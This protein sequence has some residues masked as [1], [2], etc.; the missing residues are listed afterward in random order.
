MLI[1]ILLPIIIV[2]LVDG[3]F[4]L[5]TFVSHRLLI[6]GQTLKHQRT[7]VSEPRLLARS[8]ALFH[9][10]MNIITEHQH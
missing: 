6:N 3:L 9:T 8:P 1:D 7:D 4:T 10:G 2:F 5:E